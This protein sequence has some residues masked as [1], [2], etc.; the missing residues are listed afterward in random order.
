M[1][2]NY[3]LKKIKLKRLAHLLLDGV[4]IQQHI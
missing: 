2:V 3:S 1:G 4:V